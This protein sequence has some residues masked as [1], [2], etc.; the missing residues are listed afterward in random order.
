MTKLP[1]VLYHYDA[2]P[3]A[4]KVKNML[5][6]K[7][8]P[9]KR[10]AV[11]VTLPR[12]ELAEKLG[13]TYR[14][15]PVLAIG[16]DVYCD[17]SLIASVLERRFPPSE[18]YKSL[19]PPRKGGGKADTGL[20]KA[21]TMYWTDRAVFPLAANSLPYSKFPPAFIKDRSA[22]LGTQIDPKEVEARHPIVKSQIVSHLSL[23]EEQLSDG[24]E[25]LLDTET[26]GLADLSSHFILSWIRYFRNLKDLFE[27]GTFP[28]SVSW[29]TRIAGYIDKLNKE[30]VAPFEAIDATKAAETICSALSS[31]HESVDFDDS[32][33]GRLKVEQGE[34]VSVVPS[35]NAKVPT[36]GKL[37]ALNR[38]QVV[39]ETRGSVGT[40]LCHF[41][42]LEFAVEAQSQAKL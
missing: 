24:R 41:P 15:I 31:V 42:R 33:A 16:N 29:L 23:I 38:E 9:H 20:V 27:S 37:L 2:S 40:V 14:R 22:W 8:I 21:L 11:P 32:E 5:L 4:T 7:Q 18:G 36:I 28:S 39:I 35:D 17:T 25:W 26:P 3:F 12:P 1:V 34:I 6:L 13:V 10:V 19:F 30:N